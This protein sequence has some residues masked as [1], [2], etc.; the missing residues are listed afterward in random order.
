MYAIST[1][2]VLL[3]RPFSFFFWE[4]RIFFLDVPLMNYVAFRGK[5]NPNDEDSE[6]K[7]SIEL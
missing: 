7:A 1:R 5:G 2:P 6:Y 4:D 3:Q